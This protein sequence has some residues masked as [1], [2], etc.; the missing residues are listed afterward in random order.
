MWESCEGGKGVKKGGKMGGV[1]RKRW[2]DKEKRNGGD[3]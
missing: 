3:G 1:K 2:S